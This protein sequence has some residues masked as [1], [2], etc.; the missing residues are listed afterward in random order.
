MYKKIIL[1]LMTIPFFGSGQ[2]KTEKVATQVGAAAVVT[3]GV[4]GL[5]KKKKHKDKNSSTETQN[6]TKNKTSTNSD[7]IFSV[8]TKPE[9]I[10]FNVYKCASYK[11]FEVEVF[12]NDKTG[13]IIYQKQKHCV[14]KPTIVDFGKIDDER[15]KYLKENMP[16]L[17]T[18]VDTVM[19][20]QQ[21]GIS[22]V[23]IAT[24]SSSVSEDG[25]LDT[26]HAAS[27]LTGI[28]RL[29]M[30]DGKTMKLISDNKIMMESGAWGKPGYLK[31]LQIDDENIFYEISWS[32]MHQGNVDT[33]FNYYD[34]NGNLVMDYQDYDNSAGFGKGSSN[35]KMNIDKINK[36][37]KL[38]TIE[39]KR[40]KTR[41]FQYGNGTI[42]EVKQPISSKNTI[43][44]K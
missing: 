33:F 10:L 5:F 6:T 12:T 4:I 15:A 11:D 41:T 30:T 43:E 20:F 21:N 44:K 39:G 26:F 22:N 35:T 16:T 40:K 42:T 18:K 28:I 27:A 25:N 24:V 17:A 14:W 37:I 38:T 36:T 19:S 2:N 31:L 3:A 32:D 13:E 29:Q 34:L 9:E 23:A 7:G 1:I 8:N